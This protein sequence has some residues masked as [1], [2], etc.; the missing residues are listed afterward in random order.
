MRVKFEDNAAVITD[1]CRDSQGSEIK[2]PVARE[3]AERYG[4]IASAASIIV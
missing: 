3:V 1:H 4:K 2:G